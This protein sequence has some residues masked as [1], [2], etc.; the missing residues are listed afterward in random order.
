MFKSWMDQRSRNTITA[1][2]SNER[3]S[4]APILYTD[5]LQKKQTVYFFKR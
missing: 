3:V 5:D 2:F 1:I 4:I